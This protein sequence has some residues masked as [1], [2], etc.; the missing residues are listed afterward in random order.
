MTAIHKAFRV[1][2][3]AEL[4]GLST[5]QVCLIVENNTACYEKRTIFVADRSSSLL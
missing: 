4:L 1:V 3:A 5:Y 2:Q